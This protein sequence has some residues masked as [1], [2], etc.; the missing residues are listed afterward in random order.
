V[1]ALDVLV[2]PA[3]LHLGA[4]HAQPLLEGAQRGLVLGPQLLV[5]GA[6]AGIA[7][8]KQRYVR[9]GCGE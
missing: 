8:R 9:H 4:A 7:N 5:E 2:A 6:R 1:D 3:A